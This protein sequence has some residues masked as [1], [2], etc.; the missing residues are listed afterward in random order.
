MCWTPL[1][2]TNQNNVHEPSHKQLEVK[3]NRTWFLYENRYGH[4]NTE[5]RMHNRTT[6]KTKKMTSQDRTKKVVVN[7]GASEG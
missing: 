3:T 2:V 6:Q 1:Y 7:S 4:H 5:L